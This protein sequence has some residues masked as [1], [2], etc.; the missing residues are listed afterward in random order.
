MSNFQFIQVVWLGLLETELNWTCT[1][2][3]VSLN[4]FDRSGRGRLSYNLFLKKGESYV[5]YDIEHIICYIW[6]V[7]K[8]MIFDFQQLVPLCLK[9]D[10]QQ[11]QVDPKADEMWPTF[12]QLWMTSLILGMVQL[13]YMK[14]WLICWS[15]P[16]I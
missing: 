8:S 14:D 10:V 7:L 3:K 12:D 13:L 11:I 6:Y 5:T 15:T 1:I 9:V 16:K 4:S 2:R